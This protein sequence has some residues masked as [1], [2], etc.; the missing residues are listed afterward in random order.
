M[1]FRLLLAPLLLLAAGCSTLHAPRLTAEQK[2]LNIESFQV[3]WETV[4]DKHYD[5]ELKGLDWNAI[6]EEYHPRVAQAEQMSEVRAAMRE[7]LD[8]L[9]QSHFGIIPA[10]A[11]ESIDGKDDEDEEDGDLASMVAGADG[12]DSSDSDKKDKHGYAGLDVRVL[13]GKAII[14]AVEDGYP[15][16]EKGIKTGWELLAANGRETAHIVELVSEEYADSTLLNLILSRAT[17]RKLHGDVG[18]EVE[19]RFLDGA[20]NIVE[21][22][23]VLVSEP[24][25]RTHLMGLPEQVVRIQHEMLD[26]NIGYIAFNGFWD[27]NYLMGEFGKAMK[28]F[29]E[30]DGVIIDIR[31]NGG[32]I[33]ALSMGMAGW[34]I[35]EKKMQ[36]GTMYLRNQELKFVVFPRALTYEGPVAILTDGLSASTSEIFAGGLQDLG[37]AK[38]FGTRTAAAALPSI[39][40]RLPNADGF[41][42]VFANYVS[43]GGQALEAFGVMPD[44]EIELTRESL[45]AGQ[46]LVKQAA[47]AWIQTQ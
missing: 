27:P 19:L 29:M 6:R 36:L 2:E 24:G 45:L 18:D 47:I 17:S 39:I 10:S 13:D 35:G 3:V 7:M 43:E 34:L 23:L 9:G 20:G 32:G 38:I 11:Y 4:R 42:Y 37:R 8:L 22:D 41:Q 30:S 28:S 26:G 46:D 1:P 15:G 33:G 21:T 40:E 12:D 16:A 5:A 14:T 31:G 25:N 44:V